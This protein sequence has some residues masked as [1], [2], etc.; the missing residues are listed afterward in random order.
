[1][2]P[3]TYWFI[4][5][6]FWDTNR[7]MYNTKEADKTKTWKCK[8]WKWLNHH[9]SI[10]QISKSFLKL[11]LKVTYN[12]NLV[13]TV[14]CYLGKKSAPSL[15]RNSALLCSHKNFNDWRTDRITKSVK[16]NAFSCCLVYV[17]QVKD[18][19]K[20]AFRKDLTTFLQLRGP[21]FIGH[22]RIL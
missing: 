22:M 13:A 15:Q 21:S 3:A 19:G 8:G 5:W 2:G 16:Q 4:V 11:S 1:M 18:W 10:N 14:P 6:S 12:V 17:P 20:N 7:R 9:P